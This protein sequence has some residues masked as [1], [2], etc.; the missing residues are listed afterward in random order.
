[1]TQ[2]QVQLLP[3]PK[4]FITSGYTFPKAQILDAFNWVLGLIPAFDEDTEISAVCKFPDGIDEICLTVSFITM[5]DSAEAAWNVLQ[6]AHLT[7][8]KGAILEWFFR[9][10]SFEKE[11]ANEVSAFPGGR[12]WLADNAFLNNE[13]DVAAFLEELCMSITDKHFAL[14]WY[15]LAPQSLRPLSDM[16]FSLRSDHYIG[17]YAL[18]ESE[19]DDE[20][21]QS[22]MQATAA[23]LEPFRTGS[24]SGETDFRV[25]EVKCWGDD[26]FA[27][28]TEIRQRWDP[29]G[30]I[31]GPLQ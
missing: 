29:D 31:C 11:Y 3:A 24:F 26:Q 13:A 1:V 25:R 17:T 30:R 21:C 5:K 15:P 28:L 18:Y 12:R 9:E 2:F 7:R 27:K 23:K 16:A 14:L 10:D 20:K 4:A 22:W 6:P 19:D 8:P